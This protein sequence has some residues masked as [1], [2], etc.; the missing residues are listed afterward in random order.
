[1]KVEAKLYKKLYGSDEY[2][3]ALYKPLSPVTDPG[4][5]TL[6]Y[7]K[8]AGR[9]LL[10]NEGVRYSITG[11]WE[12]DSKTGTAYIIRASACE[13]VRPTSG[14][15]IKKYLTTIDGIGKIGADRIYARFGDDTFKVL[16][17]DF[18]RLRE[19]DGINEKSFN[20]AK[21]CW[22]RRTGGKD[23]HAYL[24]AF[25]VSENI[26]TEIFDAYGD[27]A[28]EIVKRE[29]YSLIDFYGFGFKTA[30]A[31][32]RKE[33]LP[34]CSEAR[35]KAAITE[36]LKEIE[37]LGST[38]GVWSMMQP[39]VLKLLHQ[40]LSAKERSE[41]GSA[42]S[43]MAAEATTAAAKRAEQAGKTLPDGFK[44]TLEGILFTICH[45]KMKKELFIDEINGKRYIFRRE[46][47]LKEMGIAKGLKTL[48]SAKSSFS[49]DAD[50]GHVNAMLKTAAESGALA[51][52]LSSNQAEAVKL[53]LENNVC[54]ITGG[55][56]TGKTFVEKAILYALE[57]SFPGI[58]SLLLAPTGRA[59]RRM[60]DSTGRPAYTIHSALGLFGSEG[61][62]KKSAEKLDADVIII[63]ESSMIDVSLANILF[64]SIKEGSKVILVG[65][66]KQLPSVGCGSVLR[67]LLASRH[68]PTVTL[69]SVFRQAKGSSIGYNAS[70]IIAGDTKMLD[71]DSF[72]FMEIEGSNNI[73]EK[74]RDLYG[75]YCSEYGPENVTVLTPYRKGDTPTCVNAMNNSLQKSVFP[76]TER[77]YETFITGD[78]VMYTR[79]EN[80]LTNGDIGT[81][82]RI[83]KKGTA[84]QVTVNFNGEEVQLEKEDMSALELAYAT[85]I[86][87]SQ[88]S[89]YEC[90]LIIM[91]PAHK[92]LHQQ[93][94]IYTALTRAKKK[95]I[96]LGDMESFKHAVI[97]KT[98]DENRLSG[99]SAFITGTS[100]VSLESTKK[101]E[102]KEPP[103][104]G[105]QLSMLLGK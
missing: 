26:I 21:A 25:S 13:E 1:M 10:L 60:S 5:K 80:G 99:L 63:D 74:A 52:R 89:E 37:N 31:I 71:D 90:V 68:V 91:D 98:T 28:L 75:K 2:A 24:Y 8:V 58:R 48:S 81:I 42:V 96:I 55:P 23:L 76:E 49:A 73:A 43:D 104:D 9:C 87:K 47:A 56:G 4:K 3:V 94:L 19:V 15:G 61:I 32:A 97:N 86:H 41:F 39:I 46:T 44:I 7:V 92:Y 12:K 40:G 51:A 83:T 82:T 64:S 69:K 36:S 103:A 105:I 11:E 45:K 29:P 65:D 72:I 102:E 53:A 77:E 22:I 62:G 101:K 50:M 59:A 54:I 34:L 35:L 17:R 18:D 95:A 93:N 85:T 33:K 38:C 16:D 27:L 88:G 20:K 57:K 6:S 70:R 100:T 66:D 79:N 30:D 14:I 67:E 84:V 78:R